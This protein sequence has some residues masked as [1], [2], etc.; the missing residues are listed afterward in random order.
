VH[1]SHPRRTRNPAVFAGTH[2]RDLGL[3]DR[4]VRQL[5]EKLEVTKLTP[6]QQLAAPFLMMNRDVMLKSPTGTGKTLAYAVPIIQDLQGLQH[7]VRHVHAAQCSV[8]TPGHFQ[9]L[10][11]Q[12]CPSGSGSPVAHPLPPRSLLFRAPRSDARTGHLPSS[13]RQR[14]SWHSRASR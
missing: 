9:I 2:F 4:L 5:E 12:L 13:S 14:A 3:T 8:A 7:R 10:P 11:Q 6:A 1:T